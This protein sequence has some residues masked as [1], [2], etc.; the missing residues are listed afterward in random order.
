MFC[1]RIA[2]AAAVTA[3]AAA[4]LLAP[5]VVAVTPDDQVATASAT[6]EPEPRSAE[7][8]QPDMGWQ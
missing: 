5:A 6:V 2:K 3:L 8:P 4:A 7:G 1:A